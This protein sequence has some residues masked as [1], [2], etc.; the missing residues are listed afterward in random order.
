MRTSHLL[1]AAVAVA[2][3]VCAA[4]PP[5]AAM[6]GGWAPIADVNS[7]HI[8]DLGAWA[9]AEHVK[10]ANDGLQFRR[11]VSG[12]Q[13]VVSGTNYRLA[14]VAAN[15]AGEEV[16]CTAVVY[17]EWTNTRQLLSFDKKGRH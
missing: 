14:I 3:A 5:A 12:E 10:R 1:L 6:P 7:P 16:P 15:L 13:Q 9:V 17:E 2:A 4:A 11:V 8:K